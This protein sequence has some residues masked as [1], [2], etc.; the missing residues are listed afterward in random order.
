MHLLGVLLMVFLPFSA[1]TAQDVGSDRFHIAGLTYLPVVSETEETVTGRIFP[2]SLV[3][4]G[5]DYAGEG[6]GA[7]RPDWPPELPPDSFKV[8]SGEISQ[9][10]I[11]VEGVPLA[12]RYDPEGRLEEFPLMLN[13]RIVRVSIGYTEASEIREIELGFPVWVAEQGEAGHWVLSGCESWKLEFLNYLDSF[14]SIVRGSLGDAWYF[15]L[16]SRTRNEIRE[17]WYDEEG[18]FLGAYSLSRIR[19]GE[20]RRIRLLRD[21][22]NPD[23]GS[24]TEYYYDS[25]GFLTEISESG[26]FYKVLYYLEDLPRYWERN[27]G[28]I[29]GGERGNYSLQWDEN[30]FLVRITGETG[31]GLVDYRYE[32]VLDERGN[33]I[34]RREIRML[35]RMGLLVPSPGITIKRVLEYR[36]PE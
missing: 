7:W 14:P 34:E 21:F 30:G 1:L 3:L 15:I 2:I 26:G 31:D 36:E 23:N 12:F 27:P 29:A 16:I 33:W 19:I 9:A 18:S 11:E 25:R 22:S 13:G 10:V 32:Y 20:N 8:L 5:M 6:T 28:R 24:D 17:T 35:R 4:E